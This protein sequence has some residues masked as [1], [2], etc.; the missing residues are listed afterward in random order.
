MGNITGGDSY[1]YLIPVIPSLGQGVGPNN[2]IGNSINPVKLKVTVD[3]YFHRNGTLEGGVAN[4]TENAVVLAGLYK[5]R[6]FS[7]T[8]KSIRGCSAWV[9][10]TSAQKIA[11]QGRLLE[12]G[13]STVTAPNSV[14]YHNFDYPISDENWTKHKGNRT[15]FMGKQAGVGW[16]GTSPT[17][18]TPYAP[19]APGMTAHKRVTFFVKLPKVFK[20]EDVD[21]GGAAGQFYPTNFNSLWGVH[22]GVVA[23]S[24]PPQINTS[25]FTTYDGLQ[26]AISATSPSYPYNPI[27]RHTIRAELWYKDM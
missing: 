18:T 26:G 23:P 5:V 17:G 2:R 7:V 15:F 27:I 16:S 3:Y 9:D 14:S 24:Y 8:S 12:V 4:Q 11:Q 1:R 25:P 20:Y 21:V 13:D 6:Q 19:F 10:S 22:A